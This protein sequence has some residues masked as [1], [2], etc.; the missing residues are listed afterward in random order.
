MMGDEGA[1]IGQACHINKGENLAA[2]QLIEIIRTYNIDKTNILGSLLLLNVLYFID[3]QTPVNAS[4]IIKNNIKYI[5]L[6][7]SQMYFVIKEVDTAKPAVQQFIKELLS[8]KVDVI[9]SFRS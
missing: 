4:A 2:F 7:S 1:G 9:N 6:A 8:P 5:A 3:F